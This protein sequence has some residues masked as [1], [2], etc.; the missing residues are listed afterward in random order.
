MNATAA[1]SMNP[2]SPTL[3]ERLWLLAARREYGL[4]IVLALI[5]ASV[6]IKNPAFLSG[7]NIRDILINCT[8]PLIVSCGVMLVIVTGEI[9]ISVGSALALLT[10]VLGWLASPTHYHWPAWAAILAVLAMGTVL[11]LVN[12]LLVTLLRIPSIIVTLGMLTM[13]RGLTVILMKPGDITDMPYAVRFFGV[14]RI[15][16]ISTSL[17][18]TAIVVVLTALLITFTPL[19]RRIFAVGSNAHAARLSGLSV[20]RVKIF[21]FMYTGFLVGV[22]TIVTQLATVTSG[23]GQGFEL[24]VVTCVVVGGVSIS[25]GVGTMPGV[26]LGV[27][28]LQIQSTVLIFLKLGTN[29]ANW[30]QAIQGA[31]ILIAVLIDQIAGRRGKKIGGGH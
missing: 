3:G 1:I 31:L 22:A 26:V 5:I 9:D 24:L 19:G 17:W 15:L 30:N 21:A 18:I 14:G 25:G 4:A 20:T 10:A 11:G 29:A 27:I 2:S 8:Q 6:T 7:E 23:L 13:L 28:L 12:G 16:G